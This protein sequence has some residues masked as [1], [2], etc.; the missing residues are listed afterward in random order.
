MRCT[1][2]KGREDGRVSE[3]GAAAG[4]AAAREMEREASYFW[5]K[6]QQKEAEGRKC[7]TDER[8][9]LSAAAQGGRPRRLG[10]RG[11][12]SR[13]YLD[14]M[15]N[16]RRAAVVDACL[17]LACTVVERGPH[18]TGVRNAHMPMRGQS[19]SAC[20]TRR[21]A[22]SHASSGQLTTG[23]MRRELVADWEHGD[24]LAFCREDRRPHASGSLGKFRYLEG[25]DFVRTVVRAGFRETRHVRPAY[26]AP[27]AHLPTSHS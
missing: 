12:G 6:A 21:N 10:S 26:F 9:T 7:G 1:I 11:H 22:S 18:I 13:C 8:R 14:T 24:A 27:G 16:K 25:A 19:V 5:G 17:R 20:A 2:W 4:M 3:L 23:G 15:K